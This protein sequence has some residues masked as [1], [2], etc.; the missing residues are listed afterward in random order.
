MRK[1][2]QSLFAAT[3]LTFLTPT[4]AAAH[5]LGNFTVNR[6]SRLEVGRDQVQLRYVLDLAEIPTLQEL[7]ANAGPALKQGGAARERWL[8][9]KARELSDGAKLTIDRRPVSWSVQGASVELV[10]GQA[11]LD[12]LRLELVLRA[13]I[14]APDGVRLDYRDTNYAGRMGWHEVVL[15]GVDG[16]AL[17]ASTVPSSDASN[18]LRDYPTDASQRSLDVSSASATVAWAAPRPDADEPG[19]SS[20]TRSPGAVGR[21]ALDPLASRLGEIAR[22]GGGSNPIALLVALLA[23]A[24]L[25]ALHALEPGHGKTLVASYLVGARGTAR[26]AVLLGLTV[27]ATHT[28]GVYV[29][30]AVTLVAAQ[31]VLPERLYP[32][33]SAVSGLMLVGVGLTLLRSRLGSLIG[34]WPRRQR[35]GPDH[36]EHAPQ[37]DPGYDHGHSHSHSHAPGHDHGHV[38]SHHH[39]DDHDHDHDHGHG[40]AHPH[41]G[42]DYGHAHL[43]PHEAAVPSGEAGAGGLMHSHGLGGVHTHAL[44][45]GDSPVS[46][47]GLLA[48]GVSGGLLPCPA[49][50]VVLLAAISFHN[51]AL[52]LLLVAAFSAGLATVL[53]TLGLAVLYAGR[54]LGGSQRLGRLAA[55]GL[56]VAIPALGAL[57]ITGAGVAMTAEVLQVLVRLN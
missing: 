52:G 4:L 17:G 2:A 7:Q 23:A 14:Q 9:A 41:A 3:L 50:L 10:P 27:T 45:A 31:Y 1:L 46:M 15:R 21:L 37:P 57:V 56:T 55:P 20:A 30:G 33:L 28:I 5:P 16:I 49:A 38:H 34:A 48:L 35:H 32:V 8:A 47:R 12:T 22:L 13:P 42:H 11:E 54:R 6:Y 51:V 53:T 40:H 39:E 24:G 29:L 19:E 18:E 25:G 44:P 36:H 43:H 26:H